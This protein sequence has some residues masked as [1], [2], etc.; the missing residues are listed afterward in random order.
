[1]TFRTNL[2]FKKSLHSLVECQFLHSLSYVK[3]LKKNHLNFLSRGSQFYEM[4]G[5]V[6]YRNEIFLMEY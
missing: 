3:D 1:M 2:Q 6:E 5:A 4:I